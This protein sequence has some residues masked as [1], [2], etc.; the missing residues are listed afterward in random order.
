MPFYGEESSSSMFRPLPFHDAF[1]AT[2]TDADAF[3]DRFAATS[4]IVSDFSVIGAKK[5]F[6]FKAASVDINGL[7]VMCCAN[8]GIYFERE[9]TRGFDLIVPIS[10][11]IS[12]QVEQEKYVANGAELAFLTACELR[13]ST[14]I[15]SSTTL[16]LDPVRFN[17]TGKALFGSQFKEIN[18]SYTRTPALQIRDF[19][20]MPL[21]QSVFQQINSIGDAPH[22]LN[23]IGLD[24]VLYRIS[25]SF[26]HPHLLFME[27]LNIPKPLYLKSE[28]SRLCEFLRANL[29]EPISLTKM[30]EISGLPARALQRAFQH[31]FNLRPKQWLRKQRLHS[32][33]SALIDK[34]KPVK[35]TSIAYE[36]CFSSPSEFSKHYY[37]EF[38]E[39]PSETL[40]RVRY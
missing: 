29:N 18:S 32:A 31:Y 27:D 39:L 34:N 37:Q 25:V 38:G 7:W 13:K 9:D 5:D 23:K 26:L 11:H 12:R 14:T 30:E 36:Y 16:R 8:T 24:D 2:S 19:S 1:A 35:L 28:I 4:P 3:A 33:R 17:N 15:G 20:F 6:W 40:K 21:Y 22:I 10:G